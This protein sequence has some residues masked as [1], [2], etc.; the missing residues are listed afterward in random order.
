MAQDWPPCMPAAHAQC[1]HTTQNTHH[2][3]TCC[4][5]AQCLRLR[6]PGGLL[7]RVDRDQPVRIIRRQP[8]DY[9]QQQVAAAI[10]AQQRS[11]PAMPAPAYAQHAAAAA[12]ATTTATAAAATAAVAAAPTASASSAATTAARRNR[13]I[14]S[15]RARVALG[16]RASSPA[17]IPSG[18]NALKRPPGGVCAGADG[19]SE[20]VKPKILPRI[21]RAIVESARF[22]IINPLQ[23][24]NLFRAVSVAA[25][26]EIE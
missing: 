1:P 17:R 25:A 11:Q 2:Y 19:M 9:S 24:K 21:P 16:V 23:P 22:Y 3:N 5:C 14:L 6:P 20:P 12:A 7:G 15:R 4:A 8:L 18:N 13:L 26:P 10:A